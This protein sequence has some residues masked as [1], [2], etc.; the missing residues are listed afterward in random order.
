M[1][2]WKLTAPWRLPLCLS[3]MVLVL[4]L[5]HLLSYYS[6]SQPSDCKVLILS[7]IRLCGLVF[8]QLRSP[9]WQS[10]PAGKAWFRVGL[11]RSCSWELAWGFQSAVCREL[12]VF[13]VEILVF[14]ILLLI[15]SPSSVSLAS[16]QVKPPPLASDWRTCL[17]PG[18]LCSSCAVC[19]MPNVGSHVSTQCILWMW[20]LV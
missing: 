15:L 14:P 4:Y 2:G 17:L 7:G 8:C 10:L 16:V 1:S 3:C 5:S 19:C 13:L 9:L 12:D 6:Y 20:K 18:A 11:I